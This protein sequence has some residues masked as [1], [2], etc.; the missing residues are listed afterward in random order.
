LSENH[1]LIADKYVLAVFGATFSK[2]LK[3]EISAK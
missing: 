3:G 1:V 2:R